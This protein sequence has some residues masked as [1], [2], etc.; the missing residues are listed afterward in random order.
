MRKNSI[1]LSNRQRFNRTRGN[2]DYEI[3]FF[4]EKM[5]ITPQQVYDAMKQVGTNR[6]KLEN[7]FKSQTS[8]V[9]YY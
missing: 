3:S 7:Y 2:Q 5:K 6:E 1:T 4:T 8:P 9:V